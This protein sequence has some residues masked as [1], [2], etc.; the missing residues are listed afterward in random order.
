MTE[1]VGA[2]KYSTGAIAIHWIAAICIFGL[3]P[4]GFLISRLDEGPLQET[5][6]ATHQSIGLLVLFLT[7][8]RLAL[9][10]AG[11]MPACSATDTA[12]ARLL[13]R[14]FCKM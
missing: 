5:V 6:S 14:S 11:R 12:P 3:V 4:A 9:R 13:T 8:L 7:L 10:V 1:A 2:P